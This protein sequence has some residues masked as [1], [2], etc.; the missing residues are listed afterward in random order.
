MARLGKPEDVAKVAAFL[1][2]KDADYITG[3]VIAV[4]GGMT[5]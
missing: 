5:M 4:D 3:Q 1:C 2:S